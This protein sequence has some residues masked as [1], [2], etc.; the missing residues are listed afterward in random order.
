MSA[1]SPKVMGRCQEVGPWQVIR[2]RGGG[3]HEGISIL[4][5]LPASA[6]PR[7]RGHREE[8]SHHTRALLAP[9]CPPS[10]SRTVRS[11]CGLSL[12]LWFSLLWTPGRTKTQA[13][14]SYMCICFCNDTGAVCVTHI[15]GSSEE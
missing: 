9:G 7:P 6:V 3:P 11:A 8:T 14:R 4:S 15:Y 12:R 5:S 10:A 2:P 13:S 1:S